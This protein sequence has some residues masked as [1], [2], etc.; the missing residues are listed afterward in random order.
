MGFALRRL[1]RKPRSAFT[2]AANSSGDLHPEG[3]EGQGPPTPNLSSPLTFCT[4]PSTAFCLCLGCP[5]CPLSLDPG[6]A[7]PEPSS[8]GPEPLRTSGPPAAEAPPVDSSRVWQSQGWL[9]ESG[10]SV[11]AL[12]HP[13][14][15]PDA[16]KIDSR[17]RD[18]IN[19]PPQD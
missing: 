11:P 18:H 15:Q 5:I 7:R 10:L 14:L 9:P 2:K 3:N 6:G 8:L 1:S 17:V 4:Q 12:T 13:A 16:E 19:L